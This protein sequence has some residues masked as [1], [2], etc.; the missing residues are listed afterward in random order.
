MKKKMLKAIGAVLL[1]L[2]FAVNMSGCCPLLLVDFEETF[3][4]SSDFTD[5]NLESAEES[6]EDTTDATTTIVSKQVSTTH[7]VT[8]T[9]TT[10][11]ST[12]AKR[13]TSTG[14]KITTT[15]VTVIA[16]DKIPAYSGEPFTILNDN[17]PSFTAAELTTAGYENYDSLDSLGRCGVALA[18]CGVELM[19]TGERGSISSIYPTGWKQAQYDCVSGKYLY[20]RCHLIGWQLS[21]ENANKRNIITGTRYMNV[22]GMLPFENMVADYINETGNHVAYRVTPIFKGNNLLCSGVQMEAYSIEDS[23]EGIC[24]NVYC[25]NIQPN[26]IIDYADGSSYLANAVQT[27]TTLKLTTT[28]KITTTRKST[29]TT[30]EVSVIVYRTPSGKRYHLISTCG[31]K[32]SYEVTLSQAKKAGLTPCQKCAV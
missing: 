26:V 1:A 24:F 17:I 3:S 4:E 9:L 7:P 29:T 31:G 15:T 2:L 16:P 14:P 11:I 21:G 10:T 5:E 28:K 20:N 19:P 18:S 22:E 8:S 32:N 27:T 30:T 13:T 23:G 6:V 25:Y 12:S